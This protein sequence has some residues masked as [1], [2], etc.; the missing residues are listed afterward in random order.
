MAG[1]SGLAASSGP[2]ERD[3]V[4]PVS[5]SRSIFSISQ[6]RAARFRW[7]HRVGA[8]HHS[9]STP[10]A[11]RAGFRRHREPLPVH[12]RAKRRRHRRM[13]RGEAAGRDR[14][15]RRPLW[16]HHSPVE[17]RPRARGASFSWNTFT[18]RAEHPWRRLGGSGRAS[19]CGGTKTARAASSP[20]GRRGLRGCSRSS[21]WLSPSCPFSRCCS[22][23]S[24]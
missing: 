22:A 19:Y 3:L 11:E 9:G 5:L 7:R 23:W 18:D 21:L 20:P 2:A 10:L 14:G 24:R 12:A 4:R 6:R 15:N 13:C 8:P 16:F 1:E 17:C